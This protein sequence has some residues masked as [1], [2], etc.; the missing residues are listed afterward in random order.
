MILF[1]IELY[2]LKIN[3]T[4]NYYTQYCYTVI[5][6]S[7]IRW[8]FI[9]KSENPLNSWGAHTCSVGTVSYT[10]LTLPTIC[11]V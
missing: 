7:D 11:S 4:I 2:I 5:Y 8:R 3:V 6:V 10:H 9:G 1:L